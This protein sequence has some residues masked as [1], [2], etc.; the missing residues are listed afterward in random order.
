MSLREGD[1]GPA[2]TSRS[3]ESVVGVS[4]VRLCGD[5]WRAR[6]RRRSRLRS[7]TITQCARRT[8]LSGAVWAAVLSDLT[9]WSGGRDPAGITDRYIVFDLITVFMSTCIPPP[10]PPQ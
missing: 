4:A 3:T 5:R 9:S 8:S 6:R 2:E 10:P 1:S 7:R